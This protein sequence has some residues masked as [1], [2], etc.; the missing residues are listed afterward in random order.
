MST[1]GRTDPA[2]LEY[3]P[4]AEFH[5][6]GGDGLRDIGL[7]FIGDGFVAGYGD[8]KALGWVSRVVG[9][10]DT[11]DAELT[12]YNLGVRG[13]SSAD[14][15]NRWRVECPPRWA[16]RSERRLV[17]ATGAEDVAQGI[18]TARSRLNLA[19]VLDEASSTGIATFVV[20]PT[21]TLDAEV[22]DQLLVLKAA[23]AD[24]CQRREVTFVDCFTPLVTHDQWQSDLAAGDTHHPGQ[25]GYGL[26][27]WLVLNGGWQQWL[28]LQE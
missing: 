5:V 25:A 17:V 14:T 1:A 10:T 8:P 28:R 20:G 3:T 18:T 6:T 22:N 19:N 26:I 24:V 12:S 9:R 2:G 23:Q 27:A 7:C 13:S 15:M 16:G 11:T 21:P 4:S